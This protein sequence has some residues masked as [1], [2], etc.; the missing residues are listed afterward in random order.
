MKVSEV[1]AAP[2]RCLLMLRPERL[3]I[4]DG[5]MIGESAAQQ[6]V[7]RGTVQNMVYQGES[8][9]LQV[10]LADGAADQ[11]PRRIDR[12]RARDDAATW[13]ARGT[14]LRAGRRR[15]GAADGAAA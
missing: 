15:S 7:L 10:R 3:R 12:Q 13:R 8:Y 14:R 2:G 4:L 1:P 9:L 11:R 6:N 5:A